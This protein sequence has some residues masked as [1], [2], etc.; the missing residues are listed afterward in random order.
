[1]MTKSTDAYRGY[2]AK[3]ALSAMRK[4]EGLVQYCSNSIVNAMVL[5]Q[6]CTKPSICFSQ[7]AALLAMQ[8]RID[9]YRETYLRDLVFYLSAPGRQ[10]NILP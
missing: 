1:M 4:H 10:K 9:V 8:N 3:R 5:L 2:P 6:S 7:T